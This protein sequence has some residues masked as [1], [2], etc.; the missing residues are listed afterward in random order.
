MIKLYTCNKLIFLIYSIC[1][2]IVCLHA[3]DAPFIKFKL[4]KSVKQADSAKV[5]TDFNKN[6]KKIAEIRDAIGSFQTIVFP[7]KNRNSKNDTIVIVLDKQ[8]KMNVYLNLRQQFGIKR[9]EM[10]N[11]GYP[12]RIGF[13]TVWPRTMRKEEKR[14]SL[15]ITGIAP[16]Y[17]TIL[18]DTAIARAYQLL[19]AIYGNAEAE[20]FDSVAVKI[21]GTGMDYFITL[22]IKRTGDILDFRKA[23]ININANTGQIL[24]YDGPGKREPYLDFNYVPNVTKAEVLRIYE[25]EK[26]RLNADIVIR[27]VYLYWNEIRNVNRWEW[28]IYG[29]R[30][31]KILGTSAMMF[32]DSETG[33]VLFKRMY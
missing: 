4:D 31:D 1:I 14:E 9:I 23:N 8:F 16:S 18:K 25:E 24:D 26:N 21:S 12:R 27:E 30:K 3:E 11:D 32:F 10:D 5:I 6:I 22:S 13:E 33:E 29:H 19:A 7:K 17:C 15:K 20:T 2:I 28:R